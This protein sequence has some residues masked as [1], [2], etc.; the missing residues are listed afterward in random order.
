MLKIK[1]DSASLLTLNRVVRSNRLKFL[2][3]LAADM[4]GLRY[5]IIRFDPVIACNL[6]CGMCYFS[7]QDW[8]RKNVGPRFTPEQ[9][10]RIADSLFPEA[11]QLF[12]G[13]GS[14]PTMWKGYPDIVRLAKERGVPFVSLVTNAQLLT[15]D[16][17]RALADNGLDEVIV[18]VHGTREDT[19]ES[20]MKGAR[21]ARLH[22]NL[23]LLRDARDRSGRGRPAIRLN[24]TVNNDNVAQLAELFPVF[25][26]YGISTLQV[27]P[28]ADLGATTYTDKDLSPS[29]DTYRAVLERLRV[30]A[31]SA[32]TTLLVNLED[33][34]Y[35]GANK[36]AVVY[37]NAVLRYVSP[38]RVWVE[39]YDPETEAYPALK[40]RIG[41]RRSMLRWALLGS[42]ELERSSFLTTSDVV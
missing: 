32:G 12:I 5:T 27:R 1:P 28:I 26:R 20:L 16:T 40:R 7:D 34:L 15:A 22:D 3:A 2:G 31:A 13:C 21:W 11:L 6:R 8:Y 10:G 17:V 42:A 39:G 30:D 4:L 19:Y 36:R 25:G 41:F 9:V 35:R 18:S 14:E 38:Q 33:P 24:Y 23:A 29:L 37:E